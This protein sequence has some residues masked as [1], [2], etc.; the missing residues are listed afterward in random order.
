M[1]FELNPHTKVAVLMGG[2]AAER[3]ISLRSGK[4]VTEALQ[5]QGIDA[6]AID[7]KNLRQLQQVAQDFD[8]AF[9]ALH[10]RW[11]E[12]GTVQAILQD[13]KMPY[14]GSRLSASAIAMDKLRTK[15]IWRGANLPTP[16]FVW[17]SNQR[18]LAIDTFELRFPVIVKPIHEG[19]SIGMQKVERREDLPQAVQAAQVYDSDVLIEQWISGREF[20]CAV[21][22]NQA[23][24]LIELKTQN[25]FYDYQ[26]KYQSNETQY[27]C[28]VDLPIAL[29]EQIQQLVLEAFSVVG[30]ETWGR[31]DLM[32]DD[33]NQPWLIELNSVPGMT[34]HSLVPMA[35]KASGMSFAQLVKRILQ[36]AK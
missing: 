18:P 5:A 23:L 14:T 9:I 10:G 35:A 16:N 33:D 20:T 27:L 21:L 4:A 11:G 29:Q 3:D 30:A 32:L 26:A 24:P 2:L 28:P 7:V 22:E 13:L 17:V 36:R 8:V 1:A 25:S 6:K 15:W 34:D 31:V 12:D 19:S